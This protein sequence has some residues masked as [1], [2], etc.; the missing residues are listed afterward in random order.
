M[1]HPDSAELIELHRGELPED[2]AKAVE[3]HM[4]SCEKCHEEWKALGVLEQHL[5]EWHDISVSPSFV[6]ETME[7]TESERLASVAAIM[8]GKTRAAS[9]YRW[10]RR[11]SL[12]AGAVAASF[13]F[14]AMVWNPLGTPGTF[15][16]VFDLIPVAIALPAGQAVP[17]TVLVLTLYDDDTF[18]T[19]LLEGRFEV[20]DLIDELISIIDQGR[21]TKIVLVGKDPD[22]QVTF[23][24]DKLQRL[25]DEFEINDL[26]CAFRFSRTPSAQS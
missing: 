11:F 1:N 19:A 12:A 26:R 22:A 21:Y 20:E 14:Q 5:A 7:M 8:G 17:D 9:A 18:E 3:E 25:L 6:E 23:R 15:R 13:I 4:R 16:A 24:L 2:R 10:L